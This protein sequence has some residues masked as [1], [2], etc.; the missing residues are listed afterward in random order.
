MS[1][2][3]GFRF[4]LAALLLFATAL[5]AL[6]EKKVALV[7]G[8]STYKSVATLTNPRN[9][10]ADVA[11]AL[12]DLGFEVIERIDV[13]KN[14][15]RPLLK[16]FSR[17]VTDADTALVYYAGHALQYQGHYYLVPVDAGFEDPDALKYD[18]LATD[19][20]REVL[21]KV[22]GVR[23]MI[24]DACRND[25]F[26]DDPDVKP[27]PQTPPRGVTRGL[28]RVVQVHGS[29]TAY[30]TAPFDVAEDGKNRNSPFTRS[31]LKWIHEPGLEI[32]QLFMHVRNDVY[33]STNQRQLPEITISLLDDYYFNKVETDGSLWAKIRYSNDPAVLRDFLSRFPASDIAPDARYRLEVIERGKKI[34]EDFR[35]QEIQR[36]KDEQDRI[37]QQA[38]AARIKAEAEEQLRQ[39]KVRDAA[40]QADT[41]RLDQLLANGSS[42]DLAKM[43]AASSDCPDTPA[44]LAA[45]AP[46]IAAR[47]AQQAA[48][49][50]RE[51]ACASDTAAIDQLSAQGL[52]A[53]LTKM[54]TKASQ[55]PETPARI[56][57]ALAQIAAA[58]QEAA[59]RIRD[60][61]CKS[62]AARLDQLVVDGSSDDLA[63]MRA[64]TSA[65][66]ET[67]GKFAAVAT[68]IAARE[69]Q[70]VREAACASDT[71]T[72]A[73]LSAQGLSADLT[74]MKTK[75]SQCPETPARIDAALAQVALAAQ[76]AQQAAAKAREAAC[77]SDTAAI[78]QLS[79]QGLSAD[80]TKMKAKASQ[81][82]ETPARI[83]AALA[84]ITLAAQQAAA[85]TREA[86]CSADGA[87]IAQM[88]AQGRS[89]ELE[90]M[91]GKSSLCPDTPA[92]IEAAIAQIAFAAQQAAAQQLAM[93]KARDAA[94]LADNAAIAQL[95]NQRRNDELAKMRVKPSLCPDTPAKID[96]A[97]AQ[98]AAAQQQIAVQTAQDAACVSDSAA[99]A[100]LAG[101]GRADELTK[102]K[103]KPGLCP[104]TPARIDAALADLATAGEAKAQLEAKC[105]R[106]ASQISDWLQSSDTANLMQLKASSSCPETAG[107]VNKA[108]AEIQTQADAEQRRLKAEARAVQCADEANRVKSLAANADRSGLDTLK[109][110][111]TCS[112]ETANLIAAA[113]DQMFA[114]QKAVC[115]SEMAQLLALDQTHIDDISALAT[116]AKCPD[117][118]SK[119]ADLS[120]KL[121]TDQAMAANCSHE[122]EAIDHLSSLGEPGRDELKQMSSHLACAALQPTIVA[123]LGPTAIEPPT[124]PPPVNAPAI[125]TPE[126]I[127]TA[128]KSL[129]RLG[130]F[131]G[132][133][134]QPDAPQ[135]HSALRAYFKAKGEA[136]KGTDIDDTVLARLEAEPDGRVCPLVC[137]IGERE[138][139]GRCVAERTPQKD[140][141]GTRHQEQ[142]PK[143]S[144][145][146]APNTPPAA[147][148]PKKPT[149]FCVGC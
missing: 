11:T 36:A 138:R 53:D 147:E 7:I 74:K 146:A 128:Q 110:S 118:A 127:K 27:A 13:E 93:Q 131:F 24:F 47:E 64:T 20:I 134:N 137:P 72:I 82:P 87:A 34:I 144:A 90:K 77:N 38:E 78:D 56:D 62:D 117:V 145:S 23:I 105:Q 21:D 41:A 5:P 148:K 52:S 71:A 1:G 84:Q 39:R 133:V 95:A 33:Q 58:A 108:L 141:T 94:C 123:L 116:S 80:L 16:D 44:K 129:K 96:S 92:K 57:A 83:D 102:M 98:I 106:D 30:A 37:A 149:P 29:V 63:K 109:T 17:K 10:A 75:A 130:C 49:K 100:Q 81:C 107:N 25:P 112:P 91:R 26:K 136:T 73:Q 14:A 76:A 119:A 111:A 28:T 86:A 32:N 12:R 2:L 143:P 132:I 31:L 42:D 125:D 126:Q 89:D 51:A 40:C 124:N 4:L 54:K 59:A 120:Q 88:I 18:M 3:R 85:K 99:I 139:K 46:K 43:R 104:E 48:T 113:L 8:N 103:A 65:C 61:A 22:A 115:T 9:D 122:K 19:D 55:C 60:A 6:A 15:I 66:P 121:K 45:A 68:K 101:Q 35:R 114:E 67:P 50:A 140:N 135:A 70:Q 69:A 79:A 97:L 142:P